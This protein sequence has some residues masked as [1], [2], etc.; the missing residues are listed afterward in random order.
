VRPRGAVALDVG[1]LP[2][3]ANEASVDGYS[4]AARGGAR[5]GSRSQSQPVYATE[6]AVS[7]LD[8]AAG[9]V[10]GIEPLADAGSEACGAAHAATGDRAPPRSR[11]CVHGLTPPR[12]CILEVM[13]RIDLG[14]VFLVLL[15]SCA[16]H[17]E[18]SVSWW[19]QFSSGEGDARN[20]LAMDP[21][22]Q[23]DDFRS[24]VAEATGS[25]VKQSMSPGTHFGAGPGAE[26]VQA[27]R[28]RVNEKL[29]DEP[30]VTLTSID[31]SIATPG[32]GS[33]W[34]GNLAKLGAALT[35]EARRQLGDLGVAISECSGAM[36]AEASKLPTYVIRIS[37]RDLS[38]RP[39]LSEHRIEYHA[40]EGGTLQCYGFVA[41][42][43]D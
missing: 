43:D 11:S 15:A 30:L 3:Q 16:S 2:Q 13:Q 38:R 27:V 5:E 18:P 35:E 41:T 23:G 25:R 31:H 12:T 17:P 24:L 40:S 4:A 33:A 9:G 42:Q 19:I 26:E 29:G 34:P 37:G 6:F 21:L 22:F 14:I 7:W 8:M 36:D 20:C 10:P 1:A 39:F 28:V 32:D